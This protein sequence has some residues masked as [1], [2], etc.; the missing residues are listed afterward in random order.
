MALSD[1][2]T[3]VQDIARDVAGKV[4]SEQRDRAIALAVLQLGHDKPRQLVE[5][6]TGTGSQVLAMPAGWADGDSA[7]AWIEYPADQLPP[8]ELA[9]ADYAVR[10]DAVGP[11]LIFAFAVGGGDT[12]RVAYSAPHQLDDTTDTIPARQREAVACYAAAWMCDQLAAEYSAN[13]EP[14]IG[15]DSV[16]QTA[17]ARSY[18]AR[19]KT[20][21]ARYYELLAIPYGVSGGGASGATY[22]PPAAATI[23]VTPVASDGRQT[24]FKRR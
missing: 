13:T 4:T 24:L 14:T 20:Y 11:R 19:A 23:S 3:L 15:A 5:D 8:S 16:D 6:L 7:V 18:A 12:V 1:I 22:V 2:Q 17:P 10:R 21:R 9:A